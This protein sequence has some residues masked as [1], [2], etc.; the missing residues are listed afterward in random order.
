VNALTISKLVPL[1][2]FISVGFFFARW[3]RLAPLPDLT[4]DGAAAAGLLLIFAYGGY[5]VIGVPAGEARDPKRHLP[6]A[7]VATILTVTAVMTLTQMV[8]QATHP[9]LASTKTPIADA[10][11]G[12]MGPAGALFIGIGSVLS[13]TGN[14]AGQILTGSRMLFALSENG[15]L[16]GFFHFVHPRHR[17]PSNAIWFT[18][19]VALLLALSGSFVYLATVSA[20]ARLVTYTGA[21]AA[22]LALRRKSFEGSVEPATFTVPFGPLV[23][24]AAIGISLALIAGASRQQLLGGGA[25][26]LAGALLFSLTSRERREPAP[27]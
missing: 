13:M 26:L 14:N 23:P 5:D 1:A 3:G 24:L 18:S 22:T 20:V 17:T 19:T 25:A 16:P 8:A 2:V 4:L 27:R 9:D 12:F 7:F 15:A 21:C 6:F 11:L 10:A